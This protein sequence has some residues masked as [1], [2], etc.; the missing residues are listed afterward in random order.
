MIDFLKSLFDKFEPYAFV[1]NLEYMGVGMACIFVVIGA[2][3]LSVV[4]LD[5]ATTAIANRKKSEQE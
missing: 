1:E 4:V 5:K 3:A 2:I